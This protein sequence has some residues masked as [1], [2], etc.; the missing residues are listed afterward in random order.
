MSSN[1]SSASSSAAPD[2]ESEIGLTHVHLDAPPVPLECLEVLLSADEI[3]RA[4]RFYREPLRDRYVASRGMLRTILSRV[5][6]RPPDVLDFEHNEHGKPHLPD[7][8]SFN[9]SHTRDHLIVAVA[10]AGRLGVDLERI[11]PVPELESLVRRFLAPD[12]VDELMA[13]PEPERLRAFLRGWT[14]KE[15]FV[16][17][18]GRGLSVPLSS[19]VVRLAPGDGNT[20]VRTEHSG[21]WWVASVNPPAGRLEGVEVAVAWDRGPAE[22]RWVPLSGVGEDDP[23]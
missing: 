15:A 18:L 22:V 3:A 14:R 21:R 16:K 5:V 2:P 4:D 11:R 17:A 19:F 20:L 6:G 9:L 13:L 12:E 8:P 7:G 10:R 23:G 1:A